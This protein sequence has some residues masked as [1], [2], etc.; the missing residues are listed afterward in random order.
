MEI[1]TYTIRIC[2]WVYQ[3]RGWINSQTVMS[4]VRSTDIDDNITSIIIIAPVRVAPFY[5]LPFFLVCHT[6]PLLLLQTQEQPQSLPEEYVQLI[7]VNSS[8]PKNSLSV[9]PTDRQTDGQTNRH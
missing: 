3:L 9:G 2:G 5:F 6:A 1:Y 8:G 7:T 4:A